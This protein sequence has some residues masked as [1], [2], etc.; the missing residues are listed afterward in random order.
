MSWIKCSDRMPSKSIKIIVVFNNGSI[1]SAYYSTNSKK[2]R[3]TCCGSKR[4]LVTHWQPLPDPPE[5]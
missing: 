3:D 5:N 2:F 1:D 4:W